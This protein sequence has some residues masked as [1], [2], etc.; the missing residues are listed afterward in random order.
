ML[1]TVGQGLVTATQKVNRRVV[2]EKF[3]KEIKE[4]F[5]EQK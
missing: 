5:S 2:R 3:K 1:T 4:C